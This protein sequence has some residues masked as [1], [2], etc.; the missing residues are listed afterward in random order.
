MAKKLFA[1]RLEE[2]TIN[3]I[4]NLAKKSKRSTSNLMRLIVENYVEQAK[5]F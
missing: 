4:K 1:V 2:E 3:D 5:T